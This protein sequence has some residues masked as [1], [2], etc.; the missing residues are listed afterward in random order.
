MGTILLSRMLGFVREWTVAHQ[1]GSSAVTDAYYAAFTLPDFLNYLVAGGALG[2]IFIPVF[3]T[4]LTEG[5][6][7]E[8]WHVFSTVMTVM[9]LALLVLIVAGEIFTAQLV[10]LIAPGFD[11]A[12]RSEVVLLTRL[13]LPAQLFLYLG[14][15]MG[16][17]QNARARFLVPALGAIVYNVGIIAGGWLLSSRFGIIGFAIGLL[18]GT[19]CGFFL[20][21][22]IAV[23]RLGGKFTPNLDVGHPGFRMFVRLAIPIMLA[24]SI[25]FTDNWMIRWFG[26]YLAPASI[27]WLTYARTLMLVPVSTLAYGVGIASFPF[28]VQLHSEG[29]FE[30]LNRTLNITLKG[31]ILVLIPT[32]A[33]TIVLRAPITLFVFSR[34][35]L[36]AGDFHATSAALALF[37]VG[38]F[39]RGAQSL[40]SRGFNATHDTLTPAVVGTAFT[41]LTLPVYWWCG[42]RWGYLGLAAASSTG[43]IVYSVVLFGLL[44]RRTRNRQ[45]RELCLFLW[46]VSISSVVAAAVCSRLQLWLEPH[47]SADSRWGSFQTLVAVSAVGFPLV[48]LLARLLGAAEVEAYWKRLIPRTPKPIAVASE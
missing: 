15:V 40:I 32:S 39:A 29:K 10:Q 35:R 7:A 33:L 23:C 37:S 18:V 45:V 21:Q 38:M 34:T 46:R 47:V 25:D 28:L 2:L 12:Q 6:E 22:M 14:S 16:S 43:V 19:F 9:S 44:V 30:Q 1:I 31:L 13:M 3:T 36:V 48:L 17:V 11:P 41:F 4:Y 26:S 20:L 24:L 27:T 5:R 42:R 8:G